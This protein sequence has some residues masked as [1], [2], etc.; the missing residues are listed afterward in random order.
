VGSLAGKLDQEEIARTS[1]KHTDNLDAYGLFWRG[2]A[3]IRHF[4]PQDN[5][6]AREFLE[7]AIALDSNY[8]SAYASLAFTHF[9]DWRH[10]WTPGKSKDSYQKGLDL[11]YKGVSLDPSNGWARGALGFLLIYGRK[12]SQAMAQYEEGLKANPNDADLMVFLAEAYGFMGQPKEA[13]KRIKEAM[14]LNP[15]HP[16]WYFISLGYFQY[17]ACDY[18]EA[19]DTLRQMSSLGTARRILAASLAYLGRM[20]EAHAE[21]EKFLK[22]NPTFSA[23]YWGSAQPFLHDQ[24][25]QHAVEGY[26]KAGLPR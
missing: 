8:A 13:V 12:H 6:K 19:V 17:I 1:L 3:L 25:R 18:E 5:A 4:T 20:E 16:N 10:G 7:K 26:I 11:A 21:G 2:E 23:T 24:D 15:Y 9:F 14:R 22:E